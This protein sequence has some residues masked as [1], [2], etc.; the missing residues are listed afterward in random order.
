MTLP[1]RVFD[2]GL[3]PER[4]ALAWRRTALAMGVGALLGARILPDLAGLW[5]LVPS[6][7]CLAAAGGIAAASQLRYRRVHRALVAGES[8]R[9]LPDGAMIGATAGAVLAAA[10]A[11]LVIVVVLALR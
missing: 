1:D 9:G 5:T 7:L 6:L 10:A 8:P 4:T 2:A 11:A 3:Q